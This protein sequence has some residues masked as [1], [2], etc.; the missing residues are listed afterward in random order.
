MRRIFTHWGFGA[1]PTKQ[2]LE[3]YYESLKHRRHPTEAELYDLDTMP[4]PEGYEGY[5]IP[6][7][8]AGPSNRYFFSEEHQSDAHSQLNSGFRD[9]VVLRG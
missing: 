2:E 7:A 3:V 4:I 9:G 6:P 5:D 1:D 8:T